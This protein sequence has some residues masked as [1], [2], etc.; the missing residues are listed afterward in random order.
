MISPEYNIRVDNLGVSFSRSPS[1][2]ETGSFKVVV[3]QHLDTSLDREMMQL[4]GDLELEKIVNGKEVQHP[5]INPRLQECVLV[6]KI[7][8]I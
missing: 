3:S 7:Y 6:H 4:V 5:P 2:L 1:S 8:R